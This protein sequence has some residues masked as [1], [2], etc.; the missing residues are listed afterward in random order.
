MLD[1]DIRRWAV[2][3]RDQRWH[4]AIRRFGP[5][6]TPDP[7]VLDVVESDTSSIVDAL[8]P[9]L[10]AVVLWEVEPSSLR[11][12]AHQF[13]KTNESFPLAL[14]LVADGGLSVR[15]RLLL[16]EFP[17]AVLL[18]QPEQLPKIRPLIEGHFASAAQPVD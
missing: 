11:E 14:Q 9:G 17:V 5:A 4:R 2:C 8:I 13:I 12:S 18:Q 1:A 3:E 6:M 16:A 10:P 7:L 15:E